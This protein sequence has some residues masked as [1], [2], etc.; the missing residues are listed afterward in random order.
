MKI[1]VLIPEFPAQTHIFF[2]RELD[3]LREFGIDTET[4]ST[5]LPPAALM[6]HSWAKEATERT[7]YLTP[8]GIPDIASAIAALVAAGPVGLARAAASI[9]RA[10]RLGLM[11]K[12]RLMALAAMG[13]RLKR[14]AHDRGIS[15]VHVH[16][17]A[18]SAHIAMFAHLLGGPS[19][20]ITLHGSLSDYGPNQREKWRHAAFAVSLPNAYLGKFGKSSQVACRLPWR[21]HLWA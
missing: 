13:A 1:G 11:G 5:R 8:R 18:D 6:S 12:A 14:V 17:C 16:S 21:S 7:T 15:D 20:S 19:Y 3:A 2:R 9:A 10:D 4:I